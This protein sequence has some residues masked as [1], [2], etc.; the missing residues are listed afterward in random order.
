MGSV[1]CLISYSLFF[2]WRCNKDVVII[3]LCGS[4]CMSGGIR[5]EGEMVGFVVGIKLELKFKV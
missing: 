4:S 1:F 3:F 2:I 5:Y